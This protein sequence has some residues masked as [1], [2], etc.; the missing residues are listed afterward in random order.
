MTIQN[1]S[2]VVFNSLRGRAR[3]GKEGRTGVAVFVTH[4]VRTGALEIDGVDSGMN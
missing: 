2:D 1:I 3:E 4:L